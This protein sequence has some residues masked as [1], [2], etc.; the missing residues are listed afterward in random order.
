MKVKPFDMSKTLEKLGLEKITVWEKDDY[1]KVT[2]YHQ[3]I[4]EGSSAEIK[5][6][7]IDTNQ[8]GEDD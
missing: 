2:K 8:I 4:F 5:G 6:W 1:F 3:I 7:L